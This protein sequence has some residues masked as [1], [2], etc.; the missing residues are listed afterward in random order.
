MVSWIYCPKQKYANP[1]WWWA[2]G[3]SRPKPGTEKTTG[4]GL[5]TGQSWFKNLH[6]SQAKKSPSGWLTMAQTGWRTGPLFR[7]RDKW[8]QECPISSSCCSQ[9]VLRSDTHIHTHTGRGAWK[10]NPSQR[11]WQTAQINFKVF[12]SLRNFFFLIVYLI[13]YLRY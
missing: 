5:Q 8:T 9:V 1:S 13:V 10:C 11:S 6:N 3:Q 12:V 4:A 7:E 2:V